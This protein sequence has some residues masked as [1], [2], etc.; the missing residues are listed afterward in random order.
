MQIRKNGVIDCV[1][2]GLVH[3]YTFKYT[4]TYTKQIYITCT[5]M[6]SVHCGKLSNTL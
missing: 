5:P 2:G 4:P 1:S 3:M 6:Y